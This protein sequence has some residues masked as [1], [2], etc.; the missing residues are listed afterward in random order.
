[1]GITRETTAFM[2]IVKEPVLMPWLWICI[3]SHD[4]YVYGF[5]QAFKVENKC[6]KWCK[7]NS[8]SMCLNQRLVGSLDKRYFHIQYTNRRTHTLQG[9]PSGFFSVSPLSFLGKFKSD[10]HSSLNPKNDSVSCCLKLR[11]ALKS[12]TVF[13][14]NLLSSLI[15]PVP[16]V[17]N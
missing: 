1:M 7:N 8:V 12:K 17:S 3:F 4:V 16:S 6:W 14:H 11:R 13:R 10:D 5:S 2:Y 15:H 9:F